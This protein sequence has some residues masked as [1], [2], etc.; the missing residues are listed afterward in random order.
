MSLR[1]KKRLSR[2]GRRFFQRYTPEVARGLLGVK[3]VRVL[4]K[5][6][7]SGIIVETEAYRGWRDPASHAYRGITERSRVMFGRPG[8]A[9]VYFIYGFHNCLNLTTEPE[10]VPG[11]VL[12][13]ALEPS[14]GVETM[15]KNRKAIATADIS[16]GP[17]KLTQAL[18]IDRALN[19][20]DVVTSERLFLERGRK[21]ERAGVS[22]RVGVK[23]GKR[24]KWRFFDAESSHVSMEMRQRLQNP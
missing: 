5:A 2:L 11:A 15:M 17:G 24:F 13:R 7:L 10:G 22:S 19:G 4:G 9:Y 1:K 20:E 6:R 8:H 23:R 18:S 16:S 14:E 21:V 3:L 12:I